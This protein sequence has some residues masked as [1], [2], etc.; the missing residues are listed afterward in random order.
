MTQ[1]PVASCKNQPFFYNPGQNQQLQKTANLGN[2][3]LRMF[4]SSDEEDLEEEEEM[5]AKY[6][7]LNMF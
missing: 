6:L 3:D 5:K 7:I 2:S 4:K 1:E